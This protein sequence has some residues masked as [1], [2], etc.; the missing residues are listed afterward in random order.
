MGKDLKKVLLVFDELNEQEFIQSNLEENGYGVY[1]TT[2]N[3]AINLAKSI[4]PDLMVINTVNQEACTKI[5]NELGN[6]L[7]TNIIV[8]N[9]TELND[10]LTFTNQNTLTVKP[11]RPKLL[12]SLIRD[13]MSK[14]EVNWLPAVH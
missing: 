5:N 8:L 6:K 12:L 1:H 11:L 10:F 9:L 2:P 13:I 7:L 4:Q 14:R 3:E